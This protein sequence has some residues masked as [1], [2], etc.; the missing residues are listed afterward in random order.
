MTEMTE[1][2]V[3]R[4]FRRQV[5]GWLFGVHYALVML[6]ALWP[7]G[8]DGDRCGMAIRNVTRDT[9]C[10]VLARERAGV[11]LFFLLL[12]VPFGVSYLA[13]CARDGRD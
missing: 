7:V 3:P 11:T 13:R 2:D 4:R 6:T 8:E 5:Y 12:A 1:V 10:G 9:G